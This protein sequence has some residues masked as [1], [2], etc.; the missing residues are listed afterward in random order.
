MRSF[1]D[2]VGGRSRGVR[3][4][5]ASEPPQRIVQHIVTLADLWPVSRVC[6]PVMIKPE[7]IS[8]SNAR[9]RLGALK[10]PSSAGLPCAK[11]YVG[12]LKSV[13]IFLVLFPCSFA[14]R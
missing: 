12:P 11:V 4:Q 9:C 8:S 13:S 7:T 3:A 10:R 2:T 14:E 1:G 5:L 6:P